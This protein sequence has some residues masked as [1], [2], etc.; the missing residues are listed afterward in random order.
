VSHDAERRSLI[1]LLTSWGPAA[2]PA[3]PELVTLLTEGQL[4]TAVAKALTAIGPAATAAVP[5]LRVHAVGGEHRLAAATALWRLTG[6]PGPAVETVADLL[7]SD[8]LGVVELIAELGDPAR[9]LLPRMRARLAGEPG[10]SQFDQSGHVALARLVWQWTGEAE[11]ARG[12]AQAVMADGSPAP[13]AEAADLAAELGE[14]TAIATLRAVLT[15]HDT[16]AR[17]LAAHALW[18]HT[19]DAEV[20]ALTDVLTSRPNERVLRRALDVLT[21]FGPAA[22]PALPALRALSVQDATVVHYGGDDNVAA[23]DE[24]ARRAIQETI[25]SVG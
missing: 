15:E 23:L 16:W 13:R 8:E 17:L 11:G 1:E 10:V 25:A 12:A 14:P 9:R 20:Q 22:R 5:A 24:A 7:D 4:V 21:E 18:R 3:V 6:D 2:A 19:G